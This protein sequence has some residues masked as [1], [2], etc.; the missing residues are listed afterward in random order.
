MYST[1]I[2]GKIYRYN[3]RPTRHA[4]ADWWRALAGFL[5]VA[6][7]SALIY[8]RGW[9]RGIFR[10]PLRRPALDGSGRIRYLR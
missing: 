3:G 10:A 4:L 9:E 7:W 2:T 6:G 1:T 5:A 8:D